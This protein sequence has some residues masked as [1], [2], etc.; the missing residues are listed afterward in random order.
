MRWNFTMKSVCNKLPHDLE[1]PHSKVLQKSHNGAL[2]T[3]KTFRPTKGHS[4]RAYWPLPHFPWHSTWSAFFH[5]CNMS[6][7]DKMLHFR[8]STVSST[9]SQFKFNTRLKS[10]KDVF[11]R[12]HHFSLLHTELHYQA[13]IL[14]IQTWHCKTIHTA[15]KPTYPSLTL[16]IY[17]ILHKNQH[18]YIGMC[19][20]QELT[21]SSLLSRFSKAPFLIFDK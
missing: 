15:I 10:Q 16:Y 8:K 1:K 19:F 6:K 21:N 17:T 14:S 9:L 5:K 18:I 20:T 3:T 7:T 12:I 4:K 13:V 11:H 2:F